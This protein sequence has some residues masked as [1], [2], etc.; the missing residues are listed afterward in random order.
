VVYG[1]G[2]AG[3]LRPFFVSVRTSFNYFCQ[4]NQMDIQAQKLSLIKEFLSINNEELLSKLGRF[5]K[6]EKKKIYEQ[7]LK[8][9]PISQLESLID[10]VEDDVA[11]QRTIGAKQL[12]NDISKVVGRG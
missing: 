9:M 4:K 12:K 2:V 5:L 8:P 1:W 11:H 3:E 6:D 7:E 10:K